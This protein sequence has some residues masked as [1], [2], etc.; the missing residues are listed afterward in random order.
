MPGSFKKF[1]AVSF[2][3]AVLATT[4]NAAPAEAR[5]GRRGAAAVGILGA[6]AL[7]ALAVG[8]ANASPGYYGG[9]CWSE[10]RPVYNRWGDLRG[11]RNTRVCN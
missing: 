5:Y 8:A 11:Y 4:L 2:A 6:L 1:L 9:D 10:R 7:G 3:A